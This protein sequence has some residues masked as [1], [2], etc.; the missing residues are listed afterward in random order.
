M[1]NW[2]G[3]MSIFRGD[4]ELTW[5][6]Q[7]AL[8][9]AKAF[10]LF[11]PSRQVLV[12][13][14]GP[15]LTDWDA[16]ISQSAT[17]LV[18]HV[19]GRDLYVGQWSKNVPDEYQWCDLRA[20][21][22]SSADDHEF[23]A[24]SASIQRLEFLLD[25]RFCGRCGHATEL[26]PGDSGIRC[27]DTGCRAIHYP[28]IAPSVIVLVTRGDQ[29]LLAR[30]PRF[31][32]G[33]YSTLAGFIEAG[34]SAEHAIRREIREEVGIEVKN[35]T[36]FGTQSWPF[37]H[38]LMMGYLAEYA[39]GDIKVDGVEIVDANWYRRDTLPQLPLRASI[40]RALIDTWLAT[41]NH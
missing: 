22:R 38:S 36:Y 24:L 34:E 39:S 28:R 30:S 19:G 35:P 14:T 37:K 41:G 17:T 2:D 9:I 29:C 1:S 21:I 18:G 16:E 20:T 11:S 27:G 33:M 3:T 7:T 15:V 40:S 26:N 31:E 25:H 32:P 8:G 12:G 23:I 5:H 4:A 6:P 13:P 10:L